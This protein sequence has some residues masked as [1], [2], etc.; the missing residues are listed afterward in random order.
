[1]RKDDEIG[2]MRQSV[3]LP[4]GLERVALGDRTPMD[5]GVSIACPNT[6]S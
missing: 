5:R 6:T 3:L 4:N 2:R 1:M